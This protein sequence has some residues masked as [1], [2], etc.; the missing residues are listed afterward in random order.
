MSPDPPNVEVERPP[1]SWYQTLQAKLGLMF[2]LL[3]GGLC[4]LAFLLGRLLIAE[5]LQDEAQRY[6]RESGLRLVQGFEHHLAQA[7]ALARLVGRLR[8]AAE[9]A[10]APGLIPSLVADAGL[11]KLIAGHVIAR[12]STAVL[13]LLPK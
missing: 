5:P 3:A 2:V 13:A 12:P 4:L 9:P 8:K 1:L 6:Q 11:G 7:E 10:S